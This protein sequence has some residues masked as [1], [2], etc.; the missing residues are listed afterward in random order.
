MKYWRRFLST[1]DEL[2]TGL[3]VL[4]G[5]MIGFK[6]TLLVASLVRGA[7]VV[8]LMTLLTL[9]ALIWL[10]GIGREPHPDDD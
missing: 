7:P 5:S 8:A 1:W 9:M 10:M 3:R 4:I 6:L 2:S